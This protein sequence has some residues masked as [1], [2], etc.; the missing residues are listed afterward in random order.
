MISQLETALEPRRLVA[1][2][3]GPDIDALMMRVEPVPLLMPDLEIPTAMVH[4][5]E[6]LD[7]TISFR[8]QARELL[9]IRLSQITQAPARYIRILKSFERVHLFFFLPWGHLSRF[10]RQINRDEQLH[11]ELGEIKRLLVELTERQAESE[12]Q[13]K[14]AEARTREMIR[15][16]AVRS[17]SR[18]RLP[19]DPVVPGTT[20]EMSPRF[21]AV[22]ASY[23]GHLVAWREEFSFQQQLAWGGRARELVDGA[24]RA[25]KSCSALL[26]SGELDAL[27]HW[28]EFCIINPGMWML[29]LNGTGE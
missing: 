2:Q 7:P 15:A 27:C 1:S 4:Y 20:V 6:E 23:Y 22:M 29:D 9:A 26:S 25:A 14:Q 19:L 13:A 18:S 24:R 8:P 5:P 21:N 17:A 3:I 16:A 10:E 11:Q 12:K 28:L